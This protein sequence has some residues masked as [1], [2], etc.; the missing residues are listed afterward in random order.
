MLTVDIRNLYNPKWDDVSGAALY[1]DPATQVYPIQG[2]PPKPDAVSSGGV[3]RLDI[4]KLTPGEHALWIVPKN[5]SAD[6]VGV[7]TAPGINTDRIY[8]GLRIQLSTG[9]A[10]RGM[11]G[12]AIHSST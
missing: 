6:P 12:A 5:A 11:T 3:A 2:T 4:S 7:L 8:R 9:V 10:G 1:L